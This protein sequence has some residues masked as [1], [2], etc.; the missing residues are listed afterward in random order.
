MNSI[1]VNPESSWISFAFTDA[2]L[3]HVT[4]SLVSLH[5]DLNQGREESSDHL[6]HKGEA[7]RTINERLNDSNH[8]ISD[9][10]VATVAIIAN[11]EVS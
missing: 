10:S 8:E 3:L 6:Y 5:Y 11:M 2:A 1:A 9:A 4:L 7:I